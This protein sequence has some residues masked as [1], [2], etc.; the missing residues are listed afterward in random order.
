MSKHLAHIL[1]P[2][3]NH[4]GYSVTNFTDFANELINTTTI[5]DDEIMIS[6]DVA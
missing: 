5:D 6:F 4:N 3:Q 2:L 1:L